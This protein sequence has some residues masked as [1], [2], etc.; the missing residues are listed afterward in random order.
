VAMAANSSVSPGLWQPTARVLAAIFAGSAVTL[1]A[2]VMHGG[3][4]LLR[5]HETAS[6]SGS[7]V[8]PNGAPAQQLPEPSLPAPDQAATWTP[9]V[10]PPLGFSPNGQPLPPPPL[11]DPRYNV[12]LFAPPIVAAPEPP[13]SPQQ[14]APGPAPAPAPAAPRQAGN[15]PNPATPGTPQPVADPRRSGPVHGVLGS[16]FHAADGEPR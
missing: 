8:S 11:L 10:G 7:P 3:S 4:L 5:G 12:P 6:I 9:P 1:S 2:T 14:P 16:V 13:M 15:R